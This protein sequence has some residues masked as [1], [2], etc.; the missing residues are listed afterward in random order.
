MYLFAPKH[1][2]R[3]HTFVFVIRIQSQLADDVSL[4]TVKVDNE[5]LLQVFVVE[6]MKDLVQA[7]ADACSITDEAEKLKTYWE[8]SQ[9]LCL[10]IVKLLMEC[11]HLIRTYCEDKS[12]GMI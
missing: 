9:G 8:N 2:E 11:G 12:F 5:S 10:E 4:K 3:Y 1:R 6:D 7:M